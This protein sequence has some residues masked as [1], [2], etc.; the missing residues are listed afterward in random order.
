MYGIYAINETPSNSDPSNTTDPEQR[1]FDRYAEVGTESDASSPEAEHL[2]TRHSGTKAK[3]DTQN[4]S[5][6]SLSPILTRWSCTISN[7][8]L[9]FDASIYSTVAVHHSIR[10]RLEIYIN[11]FYV[12]VYR[13]TITTTPKQD[14]TSIHTIC[15]PDWPSFLCIACSSSVGDDATDPSLSCPKSSSS[16]PK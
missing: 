14:S 2:K 8:I 16:S 6:T 13:T 11:L 12:R 15:S 9:V 3:R 5:V 1:Y 7:T 10:V 4:Q